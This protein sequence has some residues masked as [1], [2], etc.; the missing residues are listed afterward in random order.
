MQAIVRTTLAALL[1]ATGLAAGLALGAGI[2]APQIAVACSCVA[3]MPLAEYAG[4]DTVIFAGTVTNSDEDG[5]L[6]NVDQWFSGTG[7][8]PV[9]LISGEFGDSAACGLGGRPP[10]GSSW[11]VVGGR[12][13][14]GGLVPELTGAPVMVSICSPFVD[15]ATPEGQALLAEA[16]ETFG[17]GRTRRQTAPSAPPTPAPSPSASAADDGGG[18]SNETL[19]TAAVVATLL[20]GLGVL[21]LALLVARRRGTGLLGVRGPRGSRRSCG[22]LRG[23]RRLI[24]ARR[25]P[26]RSTGSR[27]A[28]RAW[29]A[30]ACP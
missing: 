13:D 21:V 5:L 14:D 24:T 16:V 2:I 12:V 25:T 6:V 29:P 18:L 26:P 9:I 7:A 22:G 8:A 11:L 27:P 15:L 10:A 1:L 19:A 23:R 28:S 30:T 3:Q 20:A 4:E 17:G